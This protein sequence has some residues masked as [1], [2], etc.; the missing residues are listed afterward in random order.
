MAL[1]F[2]TGMGEMPGFIERVFQHLARH[3][4]DEYIVVD[5]G[6][7]GS[8]SFRDGT[9]DYLEY[10]VLVLGPGMATLLQVAAYGDLIRLDGKG[11]HLVLKTLDRTGAENTRPIK[12]LAA[13]DSRIIALSDI[14]EWVA[15][16]DDVFPT[17]LCD[18][19]DK[20]R[21]GQA[22]VL[23]YA[24]RD[25]DRSAAQRLGYERLLTLRQTVNWL[26]E[27][28]N[29]IIYSDCQWTEERVRALSEAIF[30]PMSEDKWE[31]SWSRLENQKTSRS[32]R[33]S[34]SITDEDLSEEVSDEFPFPLAYSFYSFRATNPQAF[35]SENLRYAEN[36]LAYLGCLGIVLAQETDPSLN[37]Q[38]DLDSLD[39]VRC[40]EGGIST[41]H[42]VKIIRE[43]SRALLK[44]EAPD[45]PVSEFPH[46][47]W[48]PGRRPRPT[49]AAKA[50]NEI[51]KIRNDFHHG[52]G[53]RTL[54]E[55][56]ESVAELRQQIFTILRHLRFLTRYPL[57]YTLDCALQRGSALHK[58][59][60][61]PC[62][63][64]HPVFQRDK[65][66]IESELY[67]EVIYLRT[68]D[69]LIDL[70]PWIVRRN[71]PECGAPSMFFVDE[72]NKSKQEIY[73][74]SFERGHSLTEKKE[75]Y[76]DEMAPALDL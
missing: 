4:P 54:E 6:F 60:Y 68:D 73:Y 56:E 32:R 38:Q 59:T 11:D 36:F 61:R 75:E 55:F 58:V 22:T 72:I 27:M 9:D 66:E 12:P 44:Y 16:A 70:T 53:P 20:L 64:S 5:Q 41:G 65:A 42:W 13:D 35:Y 69:E 62:M 49:S 74:K 47:W 23:S 28:S 29:S 7:S 57:W 76:W 40:F 2:F 1:K 43:T 26:G 48:K 31:W 15:H 19:F 37:L 34:E 10:G 50:A 63:G 30:G 33:G 24:T 52:P 25:W 8:V 18:F 17:D 51:P 67:R 39:L 3:L 46:F 71:C 45:I 14:I 21:T